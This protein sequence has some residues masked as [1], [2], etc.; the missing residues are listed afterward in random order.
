M[1]GSQ[2]MS[3]DRKEESAEGLN[4]SSRN[5][6]RVDRLE[7]ASLLGAHQIRQTA[8]FRPHFEADSISTAPPPRSP[9]FM[10]RR[11]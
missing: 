2:G 8:D 11:R 4:T 3:E 1:S 7:E 9:L 5:R 10:L 6:V